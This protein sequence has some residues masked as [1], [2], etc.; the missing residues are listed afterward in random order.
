MQLE[1]APWYAHI[2]NF[3]ATG[4]IP[5]YWKEQDRK[6][7]LAKIH[8][9]YWEEPFL[10]KYCANQIIR[11]CVPEEQQQGILSHFHENICGGHFASQ[12][13]AM[14]VLQSSFY[15]SSLFKEAHQ[16]C[17]VCDRCQRLRK[18]SRRCMLPINP[19]LEVELFDV[20]GHRFHGTF[21]Y[22]LW[23][24]IHIGGGRLCI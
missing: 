18:L 12:K 2:S 5:A 4:E 11:K 20:W 10:F 21:S 24:C 8:S 7:F 13:T 23:A 6:Y 9:Y 15:W 22:V 3:L 19:I 14:K 17:R 16:M 1:N